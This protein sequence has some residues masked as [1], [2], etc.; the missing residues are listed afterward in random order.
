[1]HIEN[2][3]S[4]FGRTMLEVLMALLI[5]GMISAGGYAGVRYALGLSQAWRAQAQV[6]QLAKDVMSLYAW[7]DSYATLSMRGNRGICNTIVSPG[8]QDCTILSPWNEE[9]SVQKGKSNASFKIVLKKTPKSICEHLMGMRFENVF[10]VQKECTS[11]PQD[12]EFLMNKDDRS[13]PEGCPPGY[14]CI[15]GECYANDREDACENINCAGECL[16]GVCRGGTCLR[17]MNGS[18]CSI[19]V[20]QEGACVEETTTTTMETTTPQETET[21]TQTD[22]QTI[23]EHPCCNTSFCSGTSWRCNGSSAYVSGDSVRFC[24]VPNACYGG[25]TFKTVNRLTY[26]YPIADRYWSAST[27]NMNWFDA[28]NFC[29]AQGMSMADQGD[30]QRNQTALQALWNHAGITSYPYVWASNIGSTSYLYSECST[31]ECYAFIQGTRTGHGSTV[32]EKWRTDVIGAKALCYSYNSY[33]T[34]TPW[35]TTTTDYTTTPYDT[36]T[37]WETTTTEGAC[38]RIYPKYSNVCLSDTSMAYN[39]SDDYCANNGMERITTN[40]AYV[41]GSAYKNYTYAWINGGYVYM[42]SSTNVYT[43]TSGSYRTLCKDKGTTL[44]YENPCTTSYD[45]LSDEIC[46]ADGVGQRYCAKAVCQTNQNVCLASI[47]TIPPSEAQ[48]FCQRVG[49][50][51]ATKEEW[52]YSKAYSGT[53]P[54]VLNGT[55]VQAWYKCCSAEANVSSQSR[56]VS[57]VV[58]VGINQV[59]EKPE[60]ECQTTSDCDKGSYCIANAQ[61]VKKCQAGS[62][63]M[64]GGICSS[65]ISVSSSDASAFCSGLGYRL[66]TKAEL[67]AAGAYWGGPGWVNNGGAVQAWYKCCSNTSTPSH[68]SWTTSAPARCK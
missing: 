51:I 49:K 58:C 48:L 16:T 24:T 67:T 57:S 22:T 32:S 55:A 19:G 61:Q 66:A 20:C 33:D 54:F 62:C 41:L 1:M 47:W 42:G 10:M 4:Q 29:A 18:S 36:T 17:K 38:K 65:N 26:P 31:R 5:L 12:V 63:S 45:C 50:R 43:S 2:K 9:V 7:Q 53:A 60:D 56:T 6:N 21:D 15:N 30:I 68:Y 46:V 25:H 39:T 37:P 14:D 28:Y 27:D 23:T 44:E 52:L 8:N 59:I 35:E 3:I 64:S 13:C 11:G 34:T 40:E